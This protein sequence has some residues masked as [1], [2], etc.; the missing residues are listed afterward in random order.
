MVD[1]KWLMVDSVA[2]S[3][4]P[5]RPRRSAG[6]K[7][8]SE[9]VVSAHTGGNSDVFPVVIGL[10]VRNGATVADVT[11]GQGVFWRKVEPERYRV[12]AS[13]LQTGVDCRALPYADDS[14]DAVVL[15]PPYMEGLHRRAQGHMAG[16]GTHGAFRARYSNGRALVTPG[17]PKY[18]DAVLAL[19][20]DAGREAQRVL[21]P[22]G[23]L[24][25]KCQD[26]VSANRQRLTHVEIINRY[27]ALDLRCEDLFVVVRPNR[28]AVSRLERQVHARKNHSYF[29]VFVKHPLASKKRRSPA[30]IKQSSQR[31]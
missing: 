4:H 16:S 5:A 26:E 2:E 24:I 7:A 1:G 15:D 10:Y 3:Q 22:G 29:L 31:E 27:A 6:G 17:A 8:T 14:I 18:H 30:K 13:D 28:P 12:L 20:F 25:V 19:Y 21:K 9:V 23:V 11:Y